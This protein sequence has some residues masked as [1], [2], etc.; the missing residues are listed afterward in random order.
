[1]RTLLF[2]FSC[3]VMSDSVTPQAA[4][5]QA[6]LSSTVSQSLLKLISIESVMPSNHII[7]CHSFLFLPSIFPSIRG[8]SNELL[9]A[10]GSQSIRASA[11]QSVLPMDVQGWFPLGLTGLIL[12]L[13]KWLSRV[14][15]KTTILKHQFWGAQSSL[16]FNSHIWALLM[17]I[18]LTI[19]T[20]VSKVMSLLFNMLS[21]FCHS[22]P[23]KEQVSFNFMAIVTVHSDFRAQENKTCHCFHFFPFCL[24]W[25]DG[26]RCLVFWM[27]SF[28][29]AFSPFL[30]HSHQESL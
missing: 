22:F 11:T 19:Q 13:T 23:S 25:S 4:A 1:M 14:F 6:P 27:L 3:Q 9:Y 15:S 28:K 8:F 24:P 17:V 12:L 30:F 20:F 21:R 10:S 16:W 26:T 5:C 18:A 2:L 7:L 29:P